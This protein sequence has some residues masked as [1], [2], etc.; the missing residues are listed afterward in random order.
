VKYVTQ[1]DPELGDIIEVLVSSLEDYNILL[2]IAYLNC[3]QAVID[4]RKINIM[5]PKIGY[6]LQCQSG[7]QA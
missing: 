4:Y 5:F 7:F 6:V 2:I 1:I 3:Y